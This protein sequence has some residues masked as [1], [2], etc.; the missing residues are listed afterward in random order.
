VCS[1]VGMGGA[2]LKRVVVVRRLG[3]GGGGLVT[4]NENVYRNSSF[5]KIEQKYPT[6]YV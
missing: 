4:F 3:G 1:G 2:G 5:V 6:F